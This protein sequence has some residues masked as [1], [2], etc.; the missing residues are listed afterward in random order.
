[1][2]H[3]PDTE[4]PT[5]LTDYLWLSTGEVRIRVVQ[6]VEVSASREGDFVDLQPSEILFTTSFNLNLEYAFYI[7]AKRFDRCRLSRI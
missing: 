4:A 7:L 1:M 6:M 3:D 2:I 5:C